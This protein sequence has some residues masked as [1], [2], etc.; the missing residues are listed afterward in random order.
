MTLAK[1]SRYAVVTHWIVAIE[2]PNS[3]PSVGNATLTMV[4]SRTV[5]IAPSTTTA[6]RVR[7][8]R[9]STDAAAGCSDGGWF[10]VSSCRVIEVVMIELIADQN[11]EAQEFYS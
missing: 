10:V 7:I 5:M 9:V 11:L 2:V 6:A 1:A 8:S 3:R 4:A